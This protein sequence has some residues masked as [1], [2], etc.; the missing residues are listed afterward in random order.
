VV[1]V[2]QACFQY[3][4]ANYGALSSVLQSIAVCC[5]VLQRVAVC[6]SMCSALLIGK[7]HPRVC[8]RVS[9]CVAVCCS[10]LHYVAVRAVPYGV[11]RV[12]REYLTFLF[13]S[14]CASLSR[15]LASRDVDTKSTCALQCAL[16]CALHC[17]VL[18]T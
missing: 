14:C 3:V 4:A 9:R 11:V 7:S 13:S 15:C 12:I 17:V 18:T 6:C 8:C 5:N 10:V 1:R 16:Q 2:I